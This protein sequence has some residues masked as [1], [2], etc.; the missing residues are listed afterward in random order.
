MEVACLNLKALGIVLALELSRSCLA[1]TSPNLVNFV[2]YPLL[3]WG[4]SLL[5]LGPLETGDCQ[6]V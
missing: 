4:F 3:I 5:S 1:H 2:N 6:S